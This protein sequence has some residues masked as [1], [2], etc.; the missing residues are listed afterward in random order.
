MVFCLAEA[1]VGK[2]LADTAISKPAFR[3]FVLIKIV[4]DDLDRKQTVFDLI[5]KAQ[6]D[7]LYLG[8]ETVDRGTRHRQFLVSQFLY[9]MPE[10]VFAFPRFD[11]LKFKFDGL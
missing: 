1:H 7:A 9:H 6:D 2:K 3:G 10:D 5:F 11:H 8:L 4:G